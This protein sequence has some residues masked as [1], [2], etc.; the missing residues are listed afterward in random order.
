M[1]INW[2][3]TCKDIKTEDWR[4]T[5][6]RAENKVVVWHIINFFGINLMPTLIVFTALIPAIIMLGWGNDKIGVF[7]F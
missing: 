6:Y 2:A 1:T 5:K 4:Y 7:S 3:Y